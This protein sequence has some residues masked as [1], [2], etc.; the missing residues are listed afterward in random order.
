MIRDVKHSLDRRQGHYER[1]QQNAL[2]LLIA[3][4]FVAGSVFGALLVVFLQGVTA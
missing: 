3:L 1:T 2:H 4:T